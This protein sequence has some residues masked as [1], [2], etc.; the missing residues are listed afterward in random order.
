MW[1][2]VPFSSTS[3]SSSQSRS[4]SRCC[5]MKRTLSFK[6]RQLSIAISINQRSPCDNITSIFSSSRTLGHKNC[7]STFNLLW[8]F[9]LSFLIHCDSV[10]VFDVFALFVVVHLFPCWFWCSHRLFGWI[11]LH[12]CALECFLSWWFSAMIPFCFKLF[13]VTVTNCSRTEV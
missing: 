12:L 9:F 10:A 8:M 2:S 6:S 1:Y 4:R 5:M 7:T 3:S 11:F 13:S